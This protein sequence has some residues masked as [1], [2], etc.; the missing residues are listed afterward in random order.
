MQ[1]ARTQPRISTQGSAL[2]QALIVLALVALA[3]LPMARKLAGAINDRG[4]AVSRVIATFEPEPG[5]GSTR[6]APPGS[7]PAGAPT[8]AGSARNPTMRLDGDD[9]ALV[10]FASDRDH[11]PG[12]Y[13]PPF[14]PGDGPGGP[15]TGTAVA[16]GALAGGLVPCLAAAGLISTTGIGILA[17]PLA[18]AVGIA[19]GAAVGGIW[20]NADEIGKGLSAAGGAISDGAHAV[21]DG[22]GKLFGGDDEG[23]DPGDEGS[24][25]NAP[26]APPS[27]QGLPDVPPG[28]ALDD[29]ALVA[30]KIAMH[31]NERAFPGIADEDVAQFIEDTMTQNPAARLRDTPSG[32]P[33]WGWWV[34]SR[35]NG[36]IIIREGNNGTAFSPDKGYDYYLGELAQ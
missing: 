25:G 23:S 4:Q 14:G 34:G 18:C 30:D 3:F 27:A 36:T 32:T 19:G 7:G 29:P 17:S 33:R 26:G 8:P 24:S 35:D 13:G 22:I 20:A 10:S 2:V 6:A 1:A 16:T 11:G 15:N 12:I 21:A 5:A 31:V 28:Y 9:I